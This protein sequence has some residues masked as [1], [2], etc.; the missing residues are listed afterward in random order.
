MA[1]TSA[2]TASATNLQR[3]VLCAQAA[4]VL[5]M[6][7]QQWGIRAESPCRKAAALARKPVAAS[8][9]PNLQALRVP[10]WVTAV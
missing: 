2:F 5:Q 6:T 10:A 8:P 4:R 1:P 3:D 7:A 9:Y